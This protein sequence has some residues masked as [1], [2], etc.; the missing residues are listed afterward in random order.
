MDYDDRLQQLIKTKDQLLESPPMRFQ[1]MTPKRIDGWETPGIYAIFRDQEVLYVGKTVNL[2]QRLYTDHLMG[3]KSTARLKKYLVEDKSLP[4]V[5]TYSD[6]KLWM[7]SHC[8]CRWLTIR[9]ARARELAELGLSYL[10][11]AKYLD[12]QE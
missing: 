5:I 8:C 1:E 12:T 7:K 2:T 10:L 3:N 9:D 4:G 11:N 6:A